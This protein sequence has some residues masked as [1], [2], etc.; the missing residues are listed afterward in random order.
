MAESP[1]ASGEGKLTVYRWNG[2]P[3]VPAAWGRSVVTIGVFDGVHR[4]HQRIIARAAGVGAELG[5]PL[6]VVTFE[7]HPD[8]VIRPG[9]HPFLLCGL[10]YRVELLGRF[11][12]DAVCVVPFSYEF[13]QLSA[14]DFVR[15]VLVD[16]LHAAAVVIG[17][18]F[19]F[20]HRAA[21]N[22]A[23]LRELGDKYEFVAEGVPLRTDQGVTVSSSW[24]RELLSSGEVGMAAAKRPAAPGRRRGGA[25]QAARTGTGISD[26]QCGAAAVYGNSW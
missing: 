2:L 26:C 25:G 21:G 23:L 1:P 24:I 5:L 16:G 7:P 18:D 22:V 8:E 10:R 15:S 14:E 6:V 9:S 17:E 3:D 19:R 12:A 20:G 11:G 13:S 4:G